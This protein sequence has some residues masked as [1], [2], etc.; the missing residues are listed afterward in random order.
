MKKLMIL[1]ALACATM[2]RAD[3]LYWSV[4]LADDSAYS[5]NYAT[6]SAKSAE[7]ETSS[8]LSLY[9]SSSTE[10]VGTRLY[11]TSYSEA[12]NWAAGTTTG[13]GAFAGF[14]KNS[15]INS[16]LI[17]LW[18]DGATQDATATR[19]GYTSLL[20]SSLAQYIYS[21][22]ATT[23]ASPYVVTDAQ[24]VPE[25]TSGLLALLGVAAL[26]LK[27]KQQKA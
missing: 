24:I 11:T 6:I 1:A 15:N 17:E 3:Y 22:M 2:A 19:V 25:P 23:G 27:R 10:P 13:G 5:F 16:F 4:N 26:A 9:G 7:S 8:T 12:N 14:D 18:T 21:D 20:Y